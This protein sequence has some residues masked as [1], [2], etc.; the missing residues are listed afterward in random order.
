MRLRKVARQ[1]Y[2]DN[3][4]AAEA[5]ARALFDAE[6]VASYAT[7]LDTQAEEHDVLD[8][9]RAAMRLRG[10]LRE[11]LRAEGSGAGGTEEE[12]VHLDDADLDDNVDADDL[13]YLELPT[14]EEVVESAAEQRALMASFE[15]QRL[16]ELA[17]CLMAAERRAAADDLA[18]VHRSSRC[19]AYIQNLAAMEELR[20]LAAADELRTVAAGRRPREDSARVE[21][22]WRLQY[23]RARAAEL[24]AMRQHQ[25]PLLSYFADANI[26][27]DAQSRRLEQVWEARLCHRLEIGNH[28]R[29]GHSGAGG[30]GHS[31]ASG[32]SAQ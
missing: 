8:T 1:R 7:D 24:A 27:E 29:S 26:A 5:A 30:D 32:S 10:E 14:D 11:E 9:A 12:Y 25:Y 16:D 31:G 4:M 19:L 17:R 28:G 3:D 22:E 2:P 18:A 13:V 6:E 20:A 15:T 21:A 23:Q